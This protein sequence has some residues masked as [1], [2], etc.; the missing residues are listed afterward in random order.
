M[1]NCKIGFAC[2]VQ[3]KRILVIDFNVITSLEL[4]YAIRAKANCDFF[5][6]HTNFLKIDLMTIK[7]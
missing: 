7:L 4:I 3:K 1:F 6:L 2:L 5:P